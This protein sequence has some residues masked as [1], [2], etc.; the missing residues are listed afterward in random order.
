MKANGKYIYSYCTNFSVPADAPVPF[1]NGEIC[2]MLSDGPLGPFTYADRV[3]KNP[4]DYFGIGGNNHHC[5]F[6]FKDQWYIAY[7]TQTLER[8]IGL[9]SGYR[10]TFIDR[11]DVQPDGHIA[12]IQGTREGVAQVQAFDPYQTIPA[13][14]AAALAGVTMQPMFGSMLL[15]TQVP[16]SWSMLSQVDFGEGTKSLTVS[17]SSV[18]DG[19]ISIVLDDVNA[20]PAAQL[21]LTRPGWGVRGPI[22]AT[23]ELPE[24]FS[25]VHDVYFVYSAPAFRISSFRF[26]R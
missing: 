5:M 6:Q 20:A 11:M 16:Q 24:S 22:E 23:C 2:T 25:G 10:C 13:A 18:C 19:T 1:K 9:G 7:H 21:T 4:A 15:Y 14:T 8:A 26:D 17:Y 12:M 3:L